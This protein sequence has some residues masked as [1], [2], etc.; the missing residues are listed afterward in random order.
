M[1]NRPTVLAALFRQIH[2]SV[3]TGHQIIL[4][5]RVVRTRR[6]PNTAADAQRLHVG[7]GETQAA[8]GFHQPGSNRTRRM[9]AVTGAQH[10]EL[11]AAQSC[12][13]FA[14]AHLVGQRLRDGNENLVAGAVTAYI[15]GVLE[16]V[17]V[18]EQQCE[19]CIVGDRLR[20]RR[21]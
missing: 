19:R 6:D 3:G 20:N 4:L 7:G 11:V 2:G 10:G 18:D 8:N 15:V 14:L 16:I 13:E 9:R 21:L 17:Q 12:G 5:T 1:V